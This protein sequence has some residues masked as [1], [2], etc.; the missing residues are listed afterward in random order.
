MGASGG[1]SEEPR[2]RTGTK[3]GRNRS[4]SVAISARRT[5]VRWFY[6][7][8]TFRRNFFPRAFR[9]EAL[10]RGNSAP[11]ELFQMFVYAA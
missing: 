8:H 3:K 5:D 2:R 7:W 6:L 11:D 9:R 1:G 10:A 4:N